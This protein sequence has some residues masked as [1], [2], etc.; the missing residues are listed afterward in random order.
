MI[1]SAIIVQV[2]C[3][4]IIALTLWGN[5]C[6]F[7]TAEDRMKALNAWRHRPMTWGALC[8]A[9]QKVTYSQHLRARLLFRDPWAL[10]DPMVLD[11]IKNPRTEVIG[12]MPVEDSDHPP[13]V[14]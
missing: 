12:V 9:Y 3:T 2:L 10:Y 5:L 11:S 4:I 7:R 6:S 8:E 1:T 14:H 13:A